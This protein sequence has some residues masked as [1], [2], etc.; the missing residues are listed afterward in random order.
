MRFAGSVT[1]VQMAFGG[2]QRPGR[3]TLSAV[4]R[5]AAG[6]SLAAGLRVA[7]CAL[8]AATAASAQD[9]RID[10]RRDGPTFYVLASADIAADPRVVW[11][12][13]T[14]YE[15]L[16]EFLPDVERSRVLARDGPR[17]TVEHRGAFRMLLFERPVRLRLAVEHEPYARIVARSAPGLVGG[18]SQ[19]L[20]AFYGRYV[21]TVVGG[22]STRVR[23]DYDAQFEL[24]EPLPPVIGPMFGTALVRG[25]MR[26]HFEAMLREIRRRQ[27][28]QPRIGKGGG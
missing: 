16:A 27:A 8:L 15:R 25:T 19:T 6:R 13:L 3:S 1:R 21:L 5:P 26:E 12:T 28:Q 24:A 10:V 14:D 20:R 7:A 2:T 11:D 18:E 9:A 17:L 23:L 22:G 4:N